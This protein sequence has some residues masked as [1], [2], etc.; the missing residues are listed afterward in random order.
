MYDTPWDPR[1]Q[2]ALRAQMTELAADIVRIRT[3][4]AAVSSPTPAPAGDAPVGGG[5][6]G[7]GGVDGGD[8]SSS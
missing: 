5:A 7:G 2:Q 6:G 4:G 8:S 3:E 1:R